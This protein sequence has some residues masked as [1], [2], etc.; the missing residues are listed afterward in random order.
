MA[1]KVIDE[2]D[3]RYRFY[4]PGCGHDHVY[5]TQQNSNHPT[6]PVWTF[7]G[8]LEN[9]TFSPSLLNRWGKEADPDWQEPEDPG[10]DGGWSGRCHLF[11]TNGE[12]DYCE[13]CTHHFNGNKKV[14]MREYPSL[15]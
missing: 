10:P 9:P 11:V 5:Y 8:N 7:N 14:P 13:D 6:D 4:C 3:G 1:N 12:I 15:D 2:G